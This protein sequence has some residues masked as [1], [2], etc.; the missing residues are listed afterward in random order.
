MRNVERVFIGGV[1]HA[2]S[3]STAAVDLEAERQSQTLLS[4]L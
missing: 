3:I 1:D 2:V 4:T